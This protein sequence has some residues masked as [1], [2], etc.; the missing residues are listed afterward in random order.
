[1]VSWTK[2][3]NSYCASTRFVTV[4]LA[5]SLLGA[6]PALAHEEPEVTLPDLK[7]THD[8]LYETFFPIAELPLTPKQ[9]LTAGALRDGFWLYLQSSPEMIEVLGGLT[10]PELLLP[11]LPPPVR[12][13]FEELGDPVVAKFL[14]VGYLG[15]SREER[16]GLFAIL[17][18]SPF[19]DLRR[20][21]ATLRTLYLSAAYDLRLSMDLTGADPG[22][23]QVADPEAWMEEHRPD[24]PASWLE[25]DP[26]AG[27]IT[28]T[29][30]PVDYLVVGSGPGG[31]TVAYR[32]REA[33]FRVV[34]VDRGSFVVP[35]GMDTR[36]PSQLKLDR[37]Q[38]ATVD[39]GILIRAGQ[40]LG[41]GSTVNVDLAFSPLEA[42]AQARISRWVEGGLVDSRYFGLQQLSQAYSWVRE[43]L[44]TEFLDQSR[45]NEN[46]RVL[47][48]GSRRY[49]V[50][51]KLYQLNRRLD[52]VTALDDKQSAVRRML[53]AAMENRDNPLAVIPDAEVVEILLTEGGDEVKARGVRLHLNAPWDNPLVVQ[54]PAGLANCR[55]QLVSLDAAN[56]VVAAGAI[57]TPEL[58]L[59]TAAR[60]P[61][62]DNPMIGRGQ[63]LHPAMPIIGLFDRHIGVLEDLRVSVF[64]D[65]FGIEP[66][67]ILEAMDAPPAYAA[68]MTPGRGRD[69]FDRVIQYNHLAGF[70]VLLVDT[71]SDAN[72][73]VL[74][75]NT[76]RAQV[77]Y[78]MTTRDKVRF[79]EGIEMA[80]RMMFLA[81][82]REV[83]IPSNEN[84]LRL[85]D[86]DPTRGTVLVCEEGKPREECA[87]VA[88]RVARNLT[89]IPNRT[90]V[91]SA[92]MQSSAKM[93]PRA[94]ISAVSWNHRVWNYQTKE[95]IPNLYVMDSSIFPTSVG[96]NPM[97]TIYT[98]AKIFSDRLIRAGALERSTF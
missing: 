36:R 78:E 13:Y 25:C 50:E 51:P 55:Q 17:L 92:H 1:M 15:L 75:P 93:G 23:W 48:E 28:A 21:A 49:G 59:R 88:T 62:L 74:D 8:A 39:G 38:L 32:L 72:R 81:G 67:F 61:A 82:A 4:A 76:G 66:G 97:Q 96:V 54:D 20:V 6:V 56:V 22:P 60:N 2:S 18:E 12:R 80:I 26:A 27:R 58:L 44:A 86:F 77:R 70:G 90:I 10:H 30:R 52:G 69:V 29:G 24:L 7:P 46:N 53:L 14:S 98:V 91:T 11:Q 16:Y 79:R 94:D 45:I 89:L 95:E 84:F 85:E 9:R 47:F 64:V 65:A 87:E 42:A 57:G 35:D 3:P 31:A 19:N 40:T 5:L 71:P 37:G 43:T 83:V 68:V 33:G 41:G 34:L 73:I 63:V